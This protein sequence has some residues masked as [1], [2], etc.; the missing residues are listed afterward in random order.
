VLFGGVSIILSRLTT[1]SDTRA[2]FLWVGA[3]VVLCRWGFM[4]DIRAEMSGVKPDLRQSRA[5]M[6]GDKPEL[7]RSHR[8]DLAA[9]CA[10]R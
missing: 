10:R 5:E 4:P 1:R 8:R 9:G 2:V 6:P 3:L 7:R